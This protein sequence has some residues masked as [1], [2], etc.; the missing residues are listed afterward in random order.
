MLITNYNNNSTN[1]NLNVHIKIAQGVCTR[2]AAITIH[3]RP[4]SSL[5]ES[6]RFFL[7]SCS[8]LRI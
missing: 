2:A 1:L 7:T 3:I 8:M 6:V 4:P 5:D